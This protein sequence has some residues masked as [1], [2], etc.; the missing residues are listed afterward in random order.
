MK[1][2]TATRLRLML[3]LSLFVIAIGASITFFF[4]TD[5][6]DS[7]ATEVSHKT[8]DAGA[9]QDTIQVITPSGAATG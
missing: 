9:S 5:Q 7:Y 1:K 4:A 2:L 8:A 3:S 6:L